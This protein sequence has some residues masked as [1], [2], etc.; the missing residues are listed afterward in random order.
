MKL[1]R[2]EL[3]CS[4]TNDKAVEESELYNRFSLKNLAA[5]TLLRSEAYSEPY[6]TSGKEPFA[7][8]NNHFLALTVWKK[9]PP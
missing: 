2:I 9:A 4:N 8:I 5:I 3:K 6:Q 7:K 1:K